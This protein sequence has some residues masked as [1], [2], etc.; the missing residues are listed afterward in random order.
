MKPFLRGTFLHFVL[1]TL[2]L[3]LV[4]CANTVERRIERNPQLFQQ[5]SA[6]DQQLVR[7]QKLREGMSRE[8]VFL[9]LGRPDRVSTGRKNGKDFER[10]TYVG[11]Q[12]V[13]TQ[14]FGMGWGGRWGGGWCGPF[15]DPFMMGGPMVTYIPYEAASVDFVS[16]RAVGWETMPR[17]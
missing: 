2:L 4:G 6:Q 12:A 14:T 1:P 11:Q 3:A 5:L 8:A 10:W 7:E 17:R 9:A 16:G 13:M 15:N